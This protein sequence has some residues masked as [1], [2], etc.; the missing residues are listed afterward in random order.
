MP[1]RMASLSFGR[2]PGARATRT[3]SRAGPGA[4]HVLQLN[5][6]AQDVQPDQPLRAS[7]SRIRTSGS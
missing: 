6:W 2:L 7:N 5:Q 3:Y 1:R 4:R